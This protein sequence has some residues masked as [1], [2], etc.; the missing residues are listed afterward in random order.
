MSRTQKTPPNKALLQAILKGEV[1]EVRRILK[2]S[3][4][5]G[6]PA[7]QRRGRPARE[8]FLM[9]AC[10]RGEKAIARMLIEHGGDVNAVNQLRQPSLPY[11]TRA[12]A[13]EI[14]SL[15]L[16]SGA[17]PNASM[18]DGDRPLHEAV[19]GGIDARITRRL[20]K[21]GADP[22]AASHRGVTPLHLAAMQNRLDVARLLLKAGADPN[23]RDRYGQGPLTCAILRNNRPIVELL[24]KSGANPQRQP[25]AL[26]VAAWEGR[27]GYVRE[28]IERGWNVNSKSHQGRTPLRHAKNRRHKAVA[29][30]LVKAGARDE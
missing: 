13:V 21:A 8:T 12:N 6:T 16:A 15:L 23:H 29:A 19:R 17:D 5:L 18:A 26:G 11:A 20:L 22:T 1:A 4:Q 27:L 28:L 3:L 7:P 14:V 30:V 25:E 10:E 2:D 24:L 9:V